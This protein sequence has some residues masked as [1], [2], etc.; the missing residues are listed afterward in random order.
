MLTPWSPAPGRMGVGGGQYV[1][2]SQ[3][4]RPCLGHTVKVWLPGNGSGA[5]QIVPGFSLLRYH[6]AGRR[7]GVGIQLAVQEQILG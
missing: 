2:Y 3:W 5:C 7:Q 4:K 1:G 6:S